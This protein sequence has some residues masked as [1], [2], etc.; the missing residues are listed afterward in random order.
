MKRLLALFTLL[1]VLVLAACS[2]GESS[3][4]NDLTMQ[5][6]ISA[7]EKEGV[8]VDVSEKP[9]FD[10]IKAKDGIIFYMDEMPV[11]IY[12]YESAKAIEDGVEALPIVKEWPKNERY[13]IETSNEKAIEIFNS[14]K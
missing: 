8:S 7:F 12:E 3:E 10:M 9:F 11:K 1:S 6:F 5:D 2:S 14:V 13:V 4:S